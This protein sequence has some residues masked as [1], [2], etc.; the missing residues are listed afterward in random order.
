MKCECTSVIGN[1]F[2]G[3]LSWK[4]PMHQTTL[5]KNW[6]MMVNPDVCGYTKPVN[7]RK[8]L[9]KTQENN[10][11][12]KLNRILK[13]GYKLSGVPVF[14]FSLP[15]ESF[16]RLTPRQLREWCKH[17]FTLRV[18]VCFACYDQPNKFP[19]TLQVWYN[20]GLKM[21]HNATQIYHKIFCEN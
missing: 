19:H 21:T 13:P 15:R 18:N 3:I 20:K 6:V 1:F 8:T 14:A 17:V 10:S 11:S 7:H 12:L 2:Q 4:R 5:K 9:W 16:A